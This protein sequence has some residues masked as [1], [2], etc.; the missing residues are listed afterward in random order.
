MPHKLFPSL[1]HLPY[2]YMN[3]LLSVNGCGEALKELFYFACLLWTKKKKKNEGRKKKSFLQ[4][5]MDAMAI[6]MLYLLLSLH[7]ATLFFMCAITVSIWNEINF[8]RSFSLRVPSTRRQL[9]EGGKI[10]YTKKKKSIFP[11]SNF[12]VFFVYSLRFS[13]S[14]CTFHIFLAFLLFIFTSIFPLSTSWFSLYEKLLWK[15]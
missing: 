13:A 1:F 10:Y 15:I 4:G 2:L 11:H 8:F 3:G 7:I 6:A 14:I 12:C 5:S 9:C